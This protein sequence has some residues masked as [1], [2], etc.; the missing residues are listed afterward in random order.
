MF[1]DSYDILDQLGEHVC[2]V[3]GGLVGTEFM[4]ELLEQG[5]R[6]TIIET[7]PEIAGKANILYKA[8]LHRLL[9]KYEDRLTILTNTAAQKFNSQGVIVTNQDGE[10]YQVES[11][12]VVIAVGLRSKSEEAMSLYGYGTETM[13]IGDCEKVGQVINAVNDAYFIAVNI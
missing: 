7:A 3:G 9:A 12:S 10:S 6:V 5:K 8:G 1:I 13:M 4:V 2:V 11:D